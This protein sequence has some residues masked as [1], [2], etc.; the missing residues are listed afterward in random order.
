MICFVIRINRCGVWHIHNLITCNYYIISKTFETCAV[1]QILANV[2]IFVA[3]TR[4]YARIPSII[5]LEYAMFYW[6]FKLKFHLCFELH[7]P[8]SNSHVGTYS[9]KLI[10]NSIKIF[11]ASDKL[12]RMA[13]IRIHISKSCSD[14]AWLIIHGY[15][16]YAEWSKKN[17]LTEYLASDVILVSSNLTAGP[18]PRARVPFIL[19][20]I[21]V[22][23]TIVNV[24]QIQCND[25]YIHIYHNKHS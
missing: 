5:L 23:M 20:I 15:T 7:F 21:K 17:I 25:H 14:H 19:L 6:F 11:I 22:T 16:F 10:L 8:W 3:L 24:H 9:T 4:T 2:T 18:S 13:F 1:F 12:I